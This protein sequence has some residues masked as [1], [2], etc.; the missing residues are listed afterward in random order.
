[1]YK[2]KYISMKFITSKNTIYKAKVYLPEINY[3][4]E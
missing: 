4:E 1:M 2:Q 3:I